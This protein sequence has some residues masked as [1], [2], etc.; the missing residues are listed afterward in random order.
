MQNTLIL[1]LLSLISTTG[2]TQSSAFEIKLKSEKFTPEVMFDFQKELTPQ[3][4]ELSQKHI[5]RIIQFYT[6]PNFTEKEQIA[7]KGIELLDYIPNKAF[8]ARISNSL[9]NADLRQLNIRSIVNLGDHQKMSGDLIEEK[10]PEWAVTGDDVLLNVSYFSK[11]DKSILIDVLTQDKSK[12][13]GGGQVV[14]DVERINMITIQYPKSQINDL[15]KIPLIQWVELV[16]S[17]LVPHSRDGL[18][19]TRSN[20]LNTDYVGGRKYDG[21][22]IVVSISD[23]GLVGPHIDLKGRM[24]QHTDENDGNHGDMTTGILAGAGNLDPTKK[25]MAPGVDINIYR[26]SQSIFLSENMHITEAVENFNNLGTIITSTS[27][28]GLAIGEY[29]NSSQ[30]IDMQLNET[31][32]LAHVFS[33]GNAGTQDSGYGAG[34]GWGNIAFG[35]QIGK[36]VITVGNL[37]INDELF[38]TSSRGPAADGRIKPDICALG[39]GHRTT[40]ENF[41][42]QIGSG[43]SAASPAL[44]GAVAQ[45]YQA[46]KEHNNGANPESSLIKAALLNTAEDLG[47]PGPDYLYGWGKVNSLKAVRIIEDN[48]YINENIEQGESKIHV[49]SVP[50]NVSQVRIMTYWADVAGSPMAAVNLVND[51]NMTVVAPD[52]TT[53]NPWILDPTPD[54]AALAAPATQG[55]DHLNNMEQVSIDNPIAGDYTVNLD[56]FAIPEGPQSYYVVYDF[57]FNEVELT[58]PLGGEGFVPGEIENIKWDASVGTEMFDLEYSEDGG[59]SFNGIGTVAATERSFAWTVPNTISGGV[60]VRIS[61]GNSISESDT[62]F[63]IAPV[64]LN[65]NIVK[66]CPDTVEL[67]WDPVAGVSKYE[68]SM[69]GQ[70]YMDSIGVSTSNSFIVTGLNP[71]NNEWFSVRSIVSESK[72]RR[73]IAINKSSGTANCILD[74]D[75]ELVQVLTNLENL[76]ACQDLENTEITINLNNVGL[77]ASTAININHQIDNGTVITETLNTDLEPGE[78]TDHIINVDMS[79]LVSGEISI[80]VEMENDQNPFN[81]TLVSPYQISNI[82][83]S[84]INTFPYF[85]GFQSFNECSIDINCEQDECTLD[86]GWSNLINNDED[87]IDWRTDSDGTATSNTGPAVDFDNGTVNGKYLYLEATSCDGKEAIVISP[88]IDLTDMVVAEAEFAYHMFGNNIGELH[89]DV[90]TQDGEFIDI[91]NPIIGNQGDVWQLLAIDLT[92]YV[93]GIINLRIRGILTFGSRGDIAIDAFT[94]KASQYPS[95]TDNLDDLASKIKIYPNPTNGDF[96]ISFSQQLVNQGLNVKIVD[97]F[98]RIIHNFETRSNN[99]DLTI[100]FPGVESGIFFVVVSGENIKVVKK[101]IK[102]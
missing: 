62:T 10:F 91:I 18:S 11:E 28:G 6:I 26:I 98:G 86:L 64:P 57:I 59:I 58:Y 54:P 4:A 66:V 45:L 73:A 39:D 27:Y 61:R 83:S 74:I 69:L 13:Q 102:L 38:F 31:P 89:V 55:V 47:N 68:I 2:I 19:T 5:Y 76:S 40:D 33:A 9:S 93:G 79:G 7:E 94:F 43:T 90:I 80:W 44:A 65:L 30:F 41:T 63:T 50:D 95:S 21:S 32:I 48:R 12:T 70:K 53:Y 96:R 20:A 92:P 34:P 52:V 17:P 56:G 25:A 16:S 35:F 42:Y 67:N 78:N 72:G 49:I 29:T 101:L 14:D 82:S 85:E 15:G 100:N 60:K 8:Y 1:F 24:T 87:D 46:Y 3:F 84:V 99:E 23:D 37:D 77:E 51:I 36:N 88:C 71:N 81:D 75:L 22:G 97:A